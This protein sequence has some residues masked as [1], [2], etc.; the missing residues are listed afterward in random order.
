MRLIAAAVG[1]S[2][3]LLASS[4]RAQDAEKVTLAWKFAKGDV[5]RY[6]M[7]ND[8]TTKVGDTEMKQ[9]LRFWLAIEPRDVTADGTATIDFRFERVRVKA[10]GMS[11]YERDSDKKEGKREGDEEADADP[12][13]Q[14]V[15]LAGRSV[16]AKVDARGRVLEAAGLD[17]IID[18]MGEGAAV[19][20]QFLGEG[21]IKEIIQAS[22]QVLPERAV[23]TGDTWDYTLEVQTP[24]LGAIKSKSRSTLRETKDGRKSALIR[25]VSTL[26]ADAA[27]GA[28]LALADGKSIA[29]T[30]WSMADGRLD[31][32]KST[33]TLLLS[34]GDEE[35]EV[36]SKVSLKRLP[37][38]KEY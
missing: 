37:K 18:A 28:M 14:L 24:A 3:L 30:M 6:E 17:K 36:S 26:E 25:T 20:R 1:L 7:G 27:A 16:T 38:G 32:L 4:A 34:A 31:A 12:T 33:I 29:E 22:F 8:I 19:F 5:L 35:I 23:A 10:S 2:T 9:E 21:Q 11:E 13:A 15:K